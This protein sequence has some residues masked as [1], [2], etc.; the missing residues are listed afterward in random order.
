M[1]DFSKNSNIYQSEF[2]SSV[3]RGESYLLSLTDLK[4]AILSF[5]TSCDSLN[6]FMSRLMNNPGIQ[7]NRGESIGQTSVSNPL[8]YD[9]FPFL[10]DIS[11]DEDDAAVQKSIEKLSKIFTTFSISKYYLVETQRLLSKHLPNE[12]S[13]FNRIASKEET[14]IQYVMHPSSCVKIA[15]ALKFFEFYIS[16]MNN[17]SNGYDDTKTTANS[18]DLISKLFQLSSINSEKRDIM[19]VLLLMCI[20][21][22]FSDVGTYSFCWISRLLYTHDLLNH[23]DNYK[24]VAIQNLIDMVISRMINDPTLFVIIPVPLLLLVSKM[25]FTF[26]KSLVKTLI[27]NPTHVSKYILNE[28]SDIDSDLNNLHHDIMH[29]M[30]SDG[31]YVLD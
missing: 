9:I 19:E 3:Q 16:P 2:L 17:L 22:T 21:P 10:M 23:I 20:S 25:H 30:K 13:S 24:K 18:H 11:K 1:N 28:L 5:Q 12:C 7:Q 31:N 15:Y 14:L 26:A 27:L 8:F 6:D 4:N 29:Q